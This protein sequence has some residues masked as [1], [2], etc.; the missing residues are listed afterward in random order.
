LDSSMKAAKR[1]HDVHPD[2]EESES[3]LAS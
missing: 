2:L 1:Y 3:S